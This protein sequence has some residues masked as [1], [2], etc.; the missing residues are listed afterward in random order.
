MG[1]DIPELPQN[2]NKQSLK[3]NKNHIDKVKSFKMAVY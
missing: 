3:V 2:N 1:G